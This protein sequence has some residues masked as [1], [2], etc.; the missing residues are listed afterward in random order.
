MSV[1]FHNTL[2]GEEEE[3]VPLEEGKVRM[4]C[5]GPT[6][7]DYFHI[8]NARTFIIF[9]ALRRYLEF[10]GYQVTFVQNVTDVEDK[11]IN[12]ANEEGKE[13]EEVASKYKK[14]YFEDL[15]KLGVKRADLNPEVTE[16]IEEIIEH[17]SAL[18]DAGYAYQV[19]GDLY[20]RVRQFSDYGKLSGRK[21]EDL[22]S[23]ARVE[24]DERKEDPLDFALWKESGPE[25][26]GWDSPWG[27]GR[28]GWHIECSVMNLHSLGETIDIHA[29]G[30]DLVFPHHE[31]EIAQAEAKTGKQ[32]V[33]YWLHNGL[34]RIDGEKM[35]KSLGNFEYAREVLERHDK[36]T[37]R[38]FYFSTHYRKPLNF[39][40]E[41]LEE[42]ARSVER[43][44]NLF[45]EVE[46]DYGSF[47]ETPEG[48]LAS[49]QPESEAGAEF[50][51]YLKGVRQEF[52]NVVDEDFNT[53]G[54]LGVVF[55]LV[56]RINKLRREEPEEAELIERG[57]A[58][59][60]Q[61]AQPLGLFQGREAPSL[62]EK[63]ERLLELLI[64]VR[65]EL[66]EER[67]WDLADRIR[68]ELE[69]MG[70]EL[71]DGEEETAWFL[72]DR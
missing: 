72:K 1:K 69:G 26:V 51:R 20:F 25:E 29:G 16:H 61:L 5:C 57:A 14:A 58:E 7:Y 46:K 8:G 70:I 17:V 33:R 63:A 37:I 67:Q 11:I 4:Y 60:R 38:F 68:D 32:F 39:S 35:S 40:E 43:V 18:Q 12:K 36:E 34:L 62:D 47:F 21:L 48:D 15:E 10:R 66:R 6:V 27:R 71:K 3:F 9:D 49:L 19:E 44:Y 52:I 24:V 28:P 13:P 30:S 56:K 64:E 42:A 53:P 41:A 54:G 65:E 23:G 22:R 59:V 55:E 31:N 50:L 45:D 2:T